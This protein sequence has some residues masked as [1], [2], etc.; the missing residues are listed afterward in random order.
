M[1]STLTRCPDVTPLDWQA[2][3]GHWRRYTPS[4]APHELVHKATL[5]YNLGR[6]TGHDI[7]CELCGRTFGSFFGI[8]SSILS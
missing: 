7:T 3:W 8:P 1:Q 6:S 4:P 2:K 5:C